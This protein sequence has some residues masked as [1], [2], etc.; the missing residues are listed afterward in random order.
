MGGQST[1]SHSTRV[2]DSK[3]LV[4]YDQEAGNNDREE[5]ARAQT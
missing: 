3:D 1:V 5:G 2:W 4:H